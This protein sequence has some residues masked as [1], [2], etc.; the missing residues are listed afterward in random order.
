VRKAVALLNDNGVEFTFRDYEKEPL[1]ATEI[2]KLLKKLK[3]SAAEVL[4]KN[5]KAYRSLGLTG[6]ESSRTLIRHM[7]AHPGL[8]NRPIGVRGRKAVLG[9]PPERLLET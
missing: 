2:E 5:D 6:K 3:M 8:L 9:R 4:R 7:A 1:S